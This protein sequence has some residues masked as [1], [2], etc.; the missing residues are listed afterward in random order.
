MKF[1]GKMRLIIIILKA[2]KNQSLTSS[3]EDTFLEKP[4]K[5]VVSNWLPLPAFSGLSSN[6]YGDVTDFEICGFYKRT[7][8]LR[9]EHSFISWSSHLISSLIRYQGLFYGKNSFVVE[10]TFKVIL[11]LVLICLVKTLLPFILL[12]PRFPKDFLLFNFSVAASLKVDSTT[13]I[14]RGTFLGEMT[15]FLLV[16]VR[17]NVLLILV[18]LLQALFFQFLVIFRPESTITRQRSCDFI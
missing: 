14:Y 7:K 1:S 12:M 9:T 3:L 6:V 8:I 18:S 2:T 10:A 11:L 17:R 15:I 13:N 5:E 16:K 4:R